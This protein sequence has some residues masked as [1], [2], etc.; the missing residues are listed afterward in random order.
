M[1][2][3]LKELLDK[4][5][6]IDKSI[7]EAVDAVTEE[8]L[9]TQK[10]ET[11][12]K[13]ADMQK[14]INDLV[15]ASKFTGGAD[16]QEAMK[17][18]A[19]QVIVKTISKIAKEKVD[20]EETVEKLFEAEMKA[21]FQNESTAEEGKEFVFDEFSRDVLTFMKQ[22]PLVDA[23]GI[24]NIKG[25]SITLPTWENLVAAYWTDEGAAITKSKGKTGKMKYDVHK[26]A[27]LVTITEEMLEDNM[28]TE[29]LYDLI[30]RSIA[31][32]QAAKVENGIIN[33]DTGK[34]E[35]ILQ[36]A[37]VAV[38]S[39]ATGNTSL[40][41]ANATAVDN[42]IIDLDVEIS[43]EFEGNPNE[44]KAIM[45]KYTLGQLKKMRTSD[46]MYVYPELRE[47]KPRL[48]KYEVIQSSK[49]PVQSLAQDIAGAKQI[50]IGNVKEFYRIVRRRDLTVVSGHADGDFQS[51][52]KSIK[53]TQ[54]LTGGL[55]TGNAFAVLAN[56]NS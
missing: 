29:D 51:D 34:M 3:E 20:G 12:S 10:A 8:K 38:V 16:N 44:A 11:E 24:I 31:N 13:I 55:I 45:S 53:G 2:P 26:L 39:L 4:L 19:K 9:K 42:A 18:A 25:T 54:R 49:M 43:P 33:G 48:G 52:L 35:G 37:D 14:Q 15:T 23:V 46:G 21:A 7:A 17:K 47:V 50:I 41:T 30:V 1:N 27:S 5:A 40:R 22:Y 36:N 32:T 28:T 6:T 56:A